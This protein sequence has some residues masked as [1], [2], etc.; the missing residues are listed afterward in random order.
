V[1]L[2][3]EALLLLTLWI[4]LSMGCFAVGFLMGKRKK[5]NPPQIT[6]E[7]KRKKEQEQRELL[8]F[9]TYNGDEQSR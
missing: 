2:V 7:E 4:V 6:Q 1:V 8:N 5:P 9:Y 3:A